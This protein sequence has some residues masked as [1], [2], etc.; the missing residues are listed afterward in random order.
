MNYIYCIKCNKH[1]KFENPKINIFN[2]TLGLYIICDKCRG[3][4]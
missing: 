1:S 4:E 3:N 2:N